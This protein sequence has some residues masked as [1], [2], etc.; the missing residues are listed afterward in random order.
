MSKRCS[1]CGVILPLAQFGVQKR[2][3]FGCKSQCKTCLAKVETVRREADPEGSRAYKRAWWAQRQFTPGERAKAAAKARAWYAVNKERQAKT[4]KL[5]MEAHREAINIIQ[6]RRRAKKR[7][8]LNTL[9]LEE[10]L[11]TLEV[12]NHACGYCLRTDLP[13]TMDHVEP[14]SHGGPHTIENIVPACKSCNCSKNNRSIFVML[15]R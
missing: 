6:A 4:V 5:W 9:T 15:N 14:I 12:F 7:S 1:A 13:L 3:L 2:G 10:W 8:V 11:Q